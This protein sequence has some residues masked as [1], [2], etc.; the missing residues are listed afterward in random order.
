MAVL[1]ANWHLVWNLFAVNLALTIF[2]IEV[3]ACEAITLLF[4]CWIFRFLDECAV[5]DTFVTEPSVFL[6]VIA[7]ALFLIHYCFWLVQWAVQDTFWTIPDAVV[8][9]EAKACLLCVDERQT[10]SVAV[11]LAVGSVEVVSWIAL[12]LFLSVG[13]GWGQS[14][15]VN[16]TISAKEFPILV[17]CTR[18]W[19]GGH[20]VRLRV[21][22]SAID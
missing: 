4:D 6:I 22:H 9:R 18:L 10:D 17:A 11:E 7:L 3:V 8:I 12:T 20:L 13:Q 14:I 16:D 1:V 21:E 19:A 2:P 15:T 5:N